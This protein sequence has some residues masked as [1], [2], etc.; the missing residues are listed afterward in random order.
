MANAFGSLI[1]RDDAHRHPSATAI[2]PGFQSA[3]AAFLQSG[4]SARARG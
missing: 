1:V 2:T 4:K 3:F